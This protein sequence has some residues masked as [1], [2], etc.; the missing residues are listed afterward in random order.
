VGWLAC[1]STGLE[2]W[3]CERHHPEASCLAWPSV[4]RGTGSAAPGVLADVRGV[5]VTSPWPVR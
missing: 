2:R 3:R 5:R 4:V 1:K